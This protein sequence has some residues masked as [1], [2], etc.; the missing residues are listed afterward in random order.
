MR[1]TD[2]RVSAYI[3]AYRDL[4][5]LNNCLQAIQQQTCPVSQIIVVDNSS[6][7]LPITAPTPETLIWR[8]PQNIGIA[9]GLYQAVRWAAGQAYDFLWMFDQDSEPQPDC[10]ERLLQSY[11]QLANH[12]PIGMIAPTPIDPRTQVIVRAE[13]FI[14]D[15]F[16]GFAPPDTTQPYECD[17]PITSGSLLNLATVE[18]VPPPEP[19]LFIDGI[20]LDYGIRLKRQ[21]FYNWVVPTAIMLHHFGSPIQLEILGQKKVFQTY[22]ALRYFYICRNHTWIELKHSQGIYK[23]SC[24]LRRLKFIISSAFWILLLD[25]KQ[26]LSKIIACI[27]GTFHGLANNFEK[28]F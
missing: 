13:R 15:R 11:V 2:H 4:G 26:K 25:P 8:Y 18:Q 21:G 14:H 23:F 9:G 5:A 27:R 22:S 19:C 6:P 28:T 17:A 1:I 16:Q 20:D 3:T 7:S 10:L 24:I 12:Y